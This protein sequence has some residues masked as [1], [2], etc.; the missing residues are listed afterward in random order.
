MYLQTPLVSWDHIHPVLVHFTTALLPVSLFSDAVGKFTDRYSFT[1]AAWWMLLY[2][3]IATPLTALA[4]WLWASEIENMSAHSYNATLATHQWLG[5]GIVLGF[6][7]LAI[8]RGRIFL[9]TRKPGIVYFTVAVVILVALMYQGY[10]GG[11][12]TLG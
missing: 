7:A 12:M 1:P 3:A 9:L 4:G 8:W 5:L 6:T 11:K 2:G 10:L